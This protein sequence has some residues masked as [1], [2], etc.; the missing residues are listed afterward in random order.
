MIFK[1]FRKEN[2]QGKDKIQ[3]NIINKTADYLRF[4]F[5]LKI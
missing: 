4:C 5:W 1:K 2:E 3:S